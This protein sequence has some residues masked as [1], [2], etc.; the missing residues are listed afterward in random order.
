MVRFHCVFSDKKG[1]FIETI[2]VIII[3]LPCCQTIQE[4]KESLQFCG[5]LL[6]CL[7]YSRYVRSTQK[8]QIHN[9]KVVAEQVVAGK[10]CSKFQQY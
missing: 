1:D 9:H 2:V 4:G 6:W 8:E 7:L 5:F 3:L 10:Y